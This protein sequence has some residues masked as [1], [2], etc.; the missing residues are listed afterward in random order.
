MRSVEI[1]WELSAHQVQQPLLH[2][3][4]AQCHT[5]SGH[6]S[7]QWAMGSEQWAVRSD[8]HGDLGGV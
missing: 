6:C 5:V 7:G 8:R 3:Q 1:T 2:L 4:C